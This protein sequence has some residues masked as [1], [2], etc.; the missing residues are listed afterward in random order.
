[1]STSP[2][3]PRIV[4]RKPEEQQQIDRETQNLAL[5]Y[6]ENCVHCIRVLRVIER[7]HLKIDFR[8]IRE[9]PAYRDQLVEHGGSS[10][11]PCLQVRKEDGDLEW[12]YESHRIIDYLEERFV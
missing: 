2:L 10:T 4:V 7:L 12:L 5:Y 9:V 8:N 6:H 3:N 1:M 11:V